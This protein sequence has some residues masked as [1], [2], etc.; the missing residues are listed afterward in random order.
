MENY[1]E[2]LSEK[3]GLS[4]MQRAIC[5]IYYNTGRAD[6]NFFP[7][8]NYAAAKSYC[9]G[10]DC[11]EYEK[12]ALKWI[13][14]NLECTV[15]TVTG[16]QKDGYCST[17]VEEVDKS[18][19][20]RFYCGDSILFGKASKDATR[21]M[22]TDDRYHNYH[23]YFALGVYWFNIIESIALMLKDD[24]QEALEPSK[25]YVKEFTDD[26]K[27]VQRSIKDRKV[28]GINGAL[29]L[30]ML[31]ERYGKFETGNNII[32]PCIPY[33]PTFTFNEP[34]ICKYERGKRRYTFF[35]SRKI[36]RFTSANGFIC[37]EIG[38]EASVYDLLNEY[39][40]GVEYLGGFI[41]TIEKQRKRW[42]EL[43]K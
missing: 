41:D 3:A 38:H 18:H 17:R 4:R 27:N 11:K 26:M 32:F 1:V 31:I 43:V 28:L 7:L 8:L 15:I 30:W 20:G 10:I 29:P 33:G 9:V 21:I 24:F 37:K 34:F 13:D 14:G 12:A 23:S 6:S 35:N 2:L 5:K 39:R 25:R 22:M 16:A 19:K 42:L 40:R 36:M